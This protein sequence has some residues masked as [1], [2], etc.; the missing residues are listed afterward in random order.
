MKVFSTKFYV[1]ILF[2][3]LFAA[4][5]KDKTDRFNVIYEVEF[6]PTWSETTHPGA[7]PTGAGFSEFVAMAHLFDVEV[8]TIGLPASNALIELATEGATNV[9]ESDFRFLINTSRALDFVVGSATSTP[10]SKTLQLGTARGYH[11]VTLLTKI[12]PSPDW[13][14]AAKTSLIDPVDGEWYNKITIEAIALDA[15][16]DTAQT[17]LPP[18]SPLDTLQDISFLNHGPLALGTDTVFGLGKFIL[19][20][21]K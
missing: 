3:V 14:L 9:F 10:N 13:F 4:C 2:L 7:Y 16:V 17:F 19:T 6:I 15:G 20:R 1:A 12:S 5:K 8:F 18:Y 21:V 11:Y